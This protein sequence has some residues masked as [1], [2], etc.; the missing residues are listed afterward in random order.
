MRECDSR[1]SIEA[2]W[3]DFH[4]STP[5]TVTFSGGKYP[6]T[7]KPL[8]MVPRFAWEPL[9]QQETLCSVKKGY[10]IS[11]K[12]IVITTFFINLTLPDYCVCTP[13]LITPHI[14]THHRIVKSELHP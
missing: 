12:Y 1:D 3:Y 6:Q 13:Y 2:A 7:R 5:H 10:L 14:Y 8:Y 9:V 11:R 4:P